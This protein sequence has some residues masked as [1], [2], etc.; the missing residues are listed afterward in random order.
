MAC[1]ISPQV[2]FSHSSFTLSSRMV[3]AVRCLGGGG[4]GGGGCGC[5]GLCTCESG[6]YDSGSCRTG[7]CPANCSGNGR[8]DY[9]TRLCE[10]NAGFIGYDC[11]MNV[12]SLT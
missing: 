9:A 3:I 6:S 8:C 12:G 4:G 7:S 2:F 11:A 5:S 10:C 1:A